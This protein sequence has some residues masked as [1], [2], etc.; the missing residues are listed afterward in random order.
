MKRTR[1]LAA[2]LALG[3]A[4]F[5]NVAPAAF[6]DGYQLKEWSDADSRI[7]N[8]GKSSADF[9]KEAYFTGYV[10]GVHDIVRGVIVCPPQNAKL[11]QLM[12]VVRKYLLA[13]PEKWNQSAGVL[14]LNALTQAFPCK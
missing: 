8:G 5:C 13:N 2:A 3:L 11:G 7:D 6:F 1:T 14:V 12:A 9:Q 4:L 10:S